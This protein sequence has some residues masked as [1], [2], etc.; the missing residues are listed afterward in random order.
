MLRRGAQHRQG[1]GAVCQ[2]AQSP[3]RGSVICGHGGGPGEL[4]GEQVVG[5]LQSR[6]AGAPLLRVWLRAHH[7]GLGE[8]GGEGLGGEQSGAAEACW[9]HNPEVDGSKPSSATAFS[10]RLLSSFCATAALPLSGQPWLWLLH[11]LCTVSLALHPSPLLSCQSALQKGPSAGQAAVEQQTYLSP[12]LCP[13][14]AGGSASYADTVTVAHPHLHMQS[15][16]TGS[17]RQ[18]R[19]RAAPAAAAREAATGVAEDGEDRG[20]SGSCASSLS[21]RMRQNGRGPP[22]G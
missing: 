6:Q 16:C 13:G 15:T 20:V 19:R 4:C 17:P 5:S 1:Q 9:A 12:Q 22:A 11:S 7:A 3:S 21:L 2:G 14:Y 18:T 10:C 8:V